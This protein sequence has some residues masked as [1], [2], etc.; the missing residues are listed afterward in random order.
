VTRRGGATR[1]LRSHNG[2]ERGIHPGRRVQRIPGGDFARC[3]IDGLPLDASFCS[4]QPRQHI[5]AAL[6]FGLYI[7]H[8]TNNWRHHAAIKEIT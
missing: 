3:G 2:V 6:A 7:L 5:G 1:A 8:N 4:V